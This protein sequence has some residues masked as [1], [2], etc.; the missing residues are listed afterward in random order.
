VAPFGAQGVLAGS[1]DAAR[2]HRVPDQVPFPSRWPTAV[3]TRADA[4]PG[5]APGRRKGKAHD[6]DHL[7]FTAP[8]VHIGSEN[9][10]AVHPCGSHGPQRSD[11]AKVPDCLLM[12]EQ[13]PS[14]REARGRYALLPVGPGSR[15]L[16]LPAVAGA[17]PALYPSSMTSGMGTG[18]SGHL[19]RVTTGERA[20]ETVDRLLR[21]LPGWFGIESSIV[22][23]VAK[24][25]ELPTYLAW[26][27]GGTASQITDSGPV[28]V[29]LAARHFPESA[30]IY[31]MAV[32]P[33]MHRRGIGSALIE[34]LEADLVADSV[35]LLQ[36]KTLGLSQAD[37]SYARTRRFYSRMG[38][39]PLE[40][41]RDLWPGNPC[42]IMVKVLRA[43]PVA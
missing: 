6:A 22:E 42:L 10:K 1:K 4:R 23:Y 16:L 13:N 14:W 37:A 27:A 28:G 5:L 21:S 35:Q 29:L 8:A 26:P 34:A 30:E 12:A 11:R 15:W 17:A 38:F 33:A 25:H 19:W 3:A 9:R 32:E 18:R 24:A 41:I 36:V 31:L 2:W 7:G 39:R 40:E 43:R 20:P